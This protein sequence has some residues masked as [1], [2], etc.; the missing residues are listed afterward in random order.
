MK[1]LTTE[2]LIS[3]INLCVTLAEEEKRSL[4]LRVIDDLALHG[5]RLSAELA[6]ELS[7]ILDFEQ[8]HL[9]DQYLPELEERTREAEAED[10]QELERIRPQLD[11]LVEDY[12]YETEEL[13]R[14]YDKAFRQI[15][16]EFDQVVQKESATKE[17]SQI[18]VIKARLKS[19]SSSE[20]SSNIHS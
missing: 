19:K 20:P 13:I 14:E 16:L 10:E 7:D 12:R 4:I 15:D 3:H 1:P 9:A 6:E 11:R 2:D 17:A 5:N 18:E 8:T